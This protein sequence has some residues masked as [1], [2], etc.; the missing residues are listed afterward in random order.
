MLNPVLDGVQLMIES[1]AAT[2]GPPDVRRYDV[3]NR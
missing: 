2:R 3:T 1:D